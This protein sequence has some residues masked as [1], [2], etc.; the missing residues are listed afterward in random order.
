[1]LSH[2]RVVWSRLVGSSELVLGRGD[3]LRGFGSGFRQEVAA[4]DRKIGQEFSGLGVGE[5]NVEQSAQMAGS[6]G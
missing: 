6:C 1:M 4:D 5:N 3:G 2:K